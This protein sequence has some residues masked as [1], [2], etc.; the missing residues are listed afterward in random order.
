[1]NDMDKYYRLLGLNPGASEEEI[2]EAYKDLVKVWHP[3]RFSNDPRLKEKAN[4]KLKEINSAYE[5]LK[6]YMAGK[7]E[8]YTAS[9]DR[10]NH[11]KSQPP[12]HEPPPTPE[13][14]QTTQTGD[15]SY[16]GFQP[17]PEQPFGQPRPHVSPIQEEK[18]TI[19]YR[20]LMIFF[21]VIGGAIGKSITNFMHFSPDEAFLYGGGIPAL[22]GGIG[23]LIGIGIVKIING[24]EKPKKHKVRLAW[25]AA[26]IGG[27]LFP[28][29][30]WFILSPF[31][32]HMQPRRSSYV[33]PPPS[34]LSEDSTSKESPF[35]AY[36]RKKERGEPNPIFEEI[37]SQT[38]KQYSQNPMPETRTPLVKG[39]KLYATNEFGYNYFDEGN[40]T[41]PSKNMVRVWVKSLF[42]DKGVISMVGQ[43][44]RRYENLSHDTSLWEVNCSEKKWRFLTST[45]YSK[46]GDVLSSS[47][48]EFEW[49]FIV[50]GTVSDL[51]LKE[52]CE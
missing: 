50:P 47:G 30:F 24:M 6:A 33:N 10:G 19:S 16:G 42:T 36:I 25:G 15:E 52:V 29:I 17:P 41:R 23:G 20:P 4:E 9:G 12:P 5:I 27:L 40:I 34:T 31:L 46:N 14:E 18:Q 51:L 37:L 26:V 1:M 11:A 21:L 49:R 3:D 35:L 43:L 39:W 48:E 7:S 45:G 8:Q 22:L 32:E 2:R 13:E 28:L 44:G 38:E